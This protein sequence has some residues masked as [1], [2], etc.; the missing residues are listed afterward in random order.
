MDH[1]VHLCAQEWVGENDGEWEKRNEEWG[2]I[3]K[4]QTLW[5]L[6]SYLFV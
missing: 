2:C 6:T 1:Y 3:D 4:S 5:A